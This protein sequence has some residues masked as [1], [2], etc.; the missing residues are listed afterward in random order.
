M[1]RKI[2][3]LSVMFFIFDFISKLIINKFLVLGKSYPLLNE[4]L[5]VT[6]AYNT[7]VS[8]GFLQ[9]YKTIIILINIAILIF[10]YLYMQKFKANKR[11]ILA[12]G[13]V[14]G[15][16]FGNLFNRIFYGYVI[17]FIDFYIVNYNFPIFN[18]ADIFICLGIFLLLYAIF[19]GED[20][21]SKSK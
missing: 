18:F 9:G 11:N 8:F 13:M 10:L 4:F 20:N 12:F 14:F 5:Y 17:D 7:G 6:K 16:L 15:G 21:E 1:K 2:G 3:L 19:L